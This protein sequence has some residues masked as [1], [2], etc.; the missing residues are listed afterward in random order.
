M[1]MTWM[2]R[3]HWL[4]NGAAWWWGTQ[5]AASVAWRLQRAPAGVAWTGA[6]TFVAPLRALRSCARRSPLRA[7]RAMRALR[8]LRSCVRWDPLVRSSVDAYQCSSAGHL[9]A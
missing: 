7:L 1:Q 3:E 5:A 8:A 2:P 6:G 4:P 9:L